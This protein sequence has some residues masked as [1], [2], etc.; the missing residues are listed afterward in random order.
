MN[1]PRLQPHLQ[2]LA[3]L[4]AYFEASA[5]LFAYREK[6]KIPERR[7]EEEFPL[8]VAAGRTFDEAYAFF[9][10]PLSESLF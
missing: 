10:E 1:A 2:E 3:V 9:T 7:P 6:T 5:K 4:R 8:Q